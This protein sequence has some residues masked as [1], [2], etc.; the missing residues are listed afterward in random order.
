MKFII[1]NEHGQYWTGTCW[2]VRQAAEEYRGLSEFPESVPDHNGIQHRRWWCEAN[3]GLFEA[4][5][6][7]DN[8]AKIRKSV[9]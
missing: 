8:F 3:D 2:G 7:D 9:K 4:G 1:E 6:G 5:Y